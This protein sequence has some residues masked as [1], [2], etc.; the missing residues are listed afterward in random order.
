[1]DGIHYMSGTQ[2]SG[3]VQIGSYESTFVVPWHARVFALGLRALGL[4]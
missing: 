4:R 2:G 3:A 1:M